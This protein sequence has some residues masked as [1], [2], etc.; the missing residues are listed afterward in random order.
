MK[1]RSAIMLAVDDDSPQGGAA[2]FTAAEARLTG[3]PVVVIHVVHGSTH[4]ASHNPLLFSYAEVEERGRQVV[5][6]VAE[7]IRGLTDGSVDVSS[8]TTRGRTVE[9]LVAASGGAHLL[10]VQ[11]RP[12]SRAGQLVSRST[13]T[14]LGARSL[15]PVVSVPSSWTAARPVIRRVVLGA[16]ERDEAW[17]LW[18]H[19]FRLAEEH[20]AGLHVVRAI[21]LPE[22][23]VAPGADLLDRRRDGIRADLEREL[24]PFRSR[25]PGV[26][27]DVELVDGPASEVLTRATGPDDLL[28][29]GRRDT[30]H[31]VYER[32]GPVSR[33][34][35]QSARCPVV[36]VPRPF[37]DAWKEAS[38]S[39]SA[40]TGA[41]ARER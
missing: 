5:T 19:G 25:Y 1:A 11:R 22:L 4:V 31:P 6:R 36:V 20:A 30:P 23:E 26:A 9:R 17:S 29:V 14:A 24:H 35:L 40:S 2:R 21:D 28:V 12:V 10:V 8:E 41:V 3:R 34:L 37:G 27:V 15:A 38:C 18:G 16:S 39:A 32:L 7:E 33:S 13:S